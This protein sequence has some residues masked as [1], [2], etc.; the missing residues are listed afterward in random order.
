MRLEEINALRELDRNE[1]IGRARHI[2]IDLDPDAWIRSFPTADSLRLAIIEKTIEREEAEPRSDD[3]ASLAEIL[4]DGLGGIEDRLSEI[5][6][7]M[8]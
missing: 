8:S 5:R 1:L 4:R 6:Q 3:V 7:G 2:G